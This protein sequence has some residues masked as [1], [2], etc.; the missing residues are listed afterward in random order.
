MPVGV[1]FSTSSLF[2]VLIDSSGHP[3]QKPFPPAKKYPDNQKHKLRKF[4]VLVCF[5]FASGL[6][7]SLGNVSDGCHSIFVIK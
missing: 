2:C 7:R 4:M 1:I 6:I 3:G 5:Q